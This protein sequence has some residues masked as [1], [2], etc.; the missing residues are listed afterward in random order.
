MSEWS[1]DEYVVVNIISVHIA[2]LQNAND[3]ED[4]YV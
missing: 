2:L 1:G 4:L 3:L